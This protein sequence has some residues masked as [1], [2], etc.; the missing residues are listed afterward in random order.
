MYVFFVVVVF[1]CVSIEYLVTAEVYTP[2]HFL[3]MMRGS[4][5]LRSEASPQRGAVFNEVEEHVQS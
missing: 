3:M 1:C 4:P 5:A 2:S